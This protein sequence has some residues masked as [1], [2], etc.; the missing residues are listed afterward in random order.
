M[1]ACENLALDREID[2]FVSKLNLGFEFLE[3]A[4]IKLVELMGRH[5]NLFQ[6]I[7][8]RHEWVTIEMLKTMEAIGK[9]QI[10]PRL[11]LAP[12]FTLNAFASLPYEEQKWAVENP[13]A[14]AQPNLRQANRRLTDMTCDEVRRVVGDGRIRSV[15]E[16]REF[17][18]QRKTL[19][20][21]L[22]KF[23]LTYMNK[24]CFLK[25]IN[26]PSGPAQKIELD[27]DG[28]AVVELVKS[29]STLPGGTGE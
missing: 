25:Q 4:G 10:H 14:V 18:D 23:L 7:T 26:E 20:V 2:D 29:S 21:T 8:D 6:Q 3:D 19:K 12:K 28:I 27:E 22:E 9:K 1:I 17:L 24:K 13:I 16:Q 5:E 15:T 11:L